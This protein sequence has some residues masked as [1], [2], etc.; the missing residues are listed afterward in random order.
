M[1]GVMNASVSLGSSQRVARVTWTPQ[2]SVPTGVSERP[3]GVSAVDSPERTGSRSRTVSTTITVRSTN[4]LMTP[5]A[6]A[7]GLALHDDARGEQ[8][9]DLCLTVAS[10]AKDLHRVLAE[11]RREAWR[12]LFD[13]GQPERARHGERSSRARVGEG[14]QGTTGDHL[15]IVPRVVHGADLTEGEA[16]AGQGFSP[17]PPWPRSEDL[18]QDGHEGARVGAPG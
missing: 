16:V 7:R 14:H 15:R 5:P 1:N 2:V 6:S 8:R 10:L 4:P 18:V 17:L 3:T 12:N 11:L 9:I 13:A